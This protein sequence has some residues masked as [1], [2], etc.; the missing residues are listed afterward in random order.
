MTFKG[1]KYVWQFFT[2]YSFAL[3]SAERHVAC[4]FDKRWNNSRWQP[5]ATFRRSCSPLIK[6]TQPTFVSW[7]P[8]IKPSATQPASMT[9]IHFDCTTWLS[10]PLERADSLL[11]LLLG[12][13]WRTHL[14]QPRYHLVRHT[15]TSE[16]STATDLHGTI[17]HG[18]S[19]HSGCPPASGR[20][21]SG[22][23]PERKKRAAVRARGFPRRLHRTR[24][25]FPRSA[26]CTKSKSIICALAWFRRIFHH[27][28]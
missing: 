15:K 11:L 5:T 3:D 23:F 8:L 21:P 19:I 20:F 28:R 9:L 4:L 1:S 17:G 13:I 18:E 12:R 22:D 6:I 16:P 7:Q 25:S 10:R 27:E 2:R 26:L 14:R 24:L